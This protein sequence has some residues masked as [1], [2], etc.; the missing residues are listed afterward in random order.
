MHKRD[1]ELIARV[2]RETPYVPRAILAKAFADELAQV[3]ERFDR[4]RFIKACG[5][6]VVMSHDP[7]IK[8]R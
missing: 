6:V 2:I 1:Y 8:I 3:S 4:N 7:E 5:V